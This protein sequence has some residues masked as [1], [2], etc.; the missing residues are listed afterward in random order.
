MNNM[1]P[2]AENNIC[3]IRAPLALNQTTLNL[4]DGSRIVKNPPWY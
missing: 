3:D 4:L 2:V 1:V